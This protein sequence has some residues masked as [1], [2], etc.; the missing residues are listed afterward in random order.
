[1]Y[2]NT[3]RIQKE[4]SAFKLGFCGR[5]EPDNRWVRMAA[6]IPWEM[7][8]PEYAHHFNNNGR[9]AK[10]FRV[11]LGSLILQETLK[12]T[13][14]ETVQ[15]ISENPCIQ[16][17]LG[18]S[19]FK[20]QIPFDASLLVYFRKRLKWES[21]AKINDLITKIVPPEME[22][23]KND[24]DDGNDDKSDSGS[25]DQKPEEPK[26]VPVQG[27]LI[28]DATCTPAD[29]RH[30]QDLSL[31][32]EARRKTENIIDV[33]HKVAGGK[34]PR[35][36]RKKARCHFLSV[37]RKRKKDPKEVQKAIRKQ[38]G[39]LGRN[40]RSINDL[41]ASMTTCRQS[42][43][44]LG[45]LST[46]QYRALLVIQET[47]S[48]QRYLLTH[49]TRSVPDRIVSISQPHIRPII[50]GKARADV[51]F[52][53]KVSVAVHNGYVF[54]D[55]ISFDAYSESHDVEMQ[56]EAYRVRTG[57]YPERILGDKAYQNQAN[58]R[59][60]KER[61]IH[62]MG[63]KMGRPFENKMIQKLF[64]KLER[65]E[66]IERV[67]IEGR[68]GIQKRRYGW[69]KISGKTP[70]TAMTM[71]MLV[72]LVANIAQRMRDSYFA[73][74]QVIVGA[75]IALDNWCTIGKKSTYL[76]LAWI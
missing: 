19:E 41:V 10:R 27:T 38:L 60:C 53:A 18:F 71:I 45:T 59:W 17:F 76:P 67:E 44:V 21:I 75:V 12:L 64:T 58:R 4:L 29:I 34:I 50:R 65:I 15:Q 42:P 47:Y 23:V 43:S 51:E 9:P 20:N 63:Q 24:N 22:S 69:D 14:R 52:G 33:L 11:A 31:I 35:T 16:F 13:D 66:E 39:Y 30:P 25:N 6:V 3:A 70:A 2:D 62:L 57:A 48:Q 54:V 40:L 5:I 72:A 28:L 46:R 61:G 1:M 68:I 37:I 56:A 26:K 8:E 55:R 73:L 36:Y 7:L 32:D 49:K 74:I